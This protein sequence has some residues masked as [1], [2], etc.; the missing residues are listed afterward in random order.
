MRLFQ[1][2]ND[3]FELKDVSDEHVEV[4]QRL[5]TI[6]LAR[7]DQQREREHAFASLSPSVD[8]EMDPTI[9]EELRAL[10]Y[11]Y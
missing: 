10:G 1:L 2:S 7:L 9:L 6:L 5:R 3:P 4:A 11:V 8:N